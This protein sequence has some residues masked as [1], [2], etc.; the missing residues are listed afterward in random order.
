MRNEKDN[1][2]ISMEV[3]NKFI[4]ILQ[5]YSNTGIPN[6]DILAIFMTSISIFTAQFISMIVED[7]DEDEKF[8]IVAVIAN[9][10]KNIMPIFS[11]KQEHLGENNEK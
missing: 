7:G 11:G 10:A 2:E 6:R 5:E 8:R 4:S 9:S 3:H 1:A